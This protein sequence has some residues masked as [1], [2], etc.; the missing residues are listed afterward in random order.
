M[1]RQESISPGTDFAGGRHYGLDWL[2]I[3][4]FAILIFY[5]IGL[6]FVNGEWL[7]K[8]AE[9]VEWLAIPMVFTTP[10]RLALLFAVSGFASAAL[11]GKLGGVERFVRERSKRLL[12]PLVF[13]MAVIIPPQSWVGL[14]FN[15]GLTESYWSFWSTDYFR[16]GQL[17]GVTLPGWEHLW[18]VAYLWAFTMVLAIGHV[19]ASGAIRRR[20][21]A[22]IDWM[23]QG[24][25]LF[26]L[27]LVYFVP[28]RAGITFTLGESHGLFDDWLTDALYLPVFLFGFALARSPQLWPA[29]MRC[30]RS[31]LL[32]A[33]ASY[34][35]LA[36]LEI[37]FPDMEGISHA[38]MALDRA[39]VGAMMWAMVLFML[40][41]GTRFLNRDHRWR[42]TLS[43]AIFPIYILHQTA[44]VLIGWWL[45]PYGLPPLAEFA[46]ILT[47]TASSCALFYLVARR[48][49]WLAPVA[50]LSA[51]KDTQVAT[52][53]MAEP[54]RQS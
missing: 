2:R 13:A 45:L 28:V 25:R 33:L 16:F 21:V 46:I 22:A 26:W 5:H 48:V 39:A 29:I 42:K 23:A 53:P 14:S 7:V 15:H 40:A 31:A 50:G 37:R 30:A 47:G 52:A 11:L 32:L 35:V 34:A 44:I 12:I 19:F 8:T 27:P 1:Q 4:A 49:S 41:I 6:F 54:A 38:E 24:Y 43:E 9:P 20:I 36:A 17:H 3:G 51:R 10:W 18:F